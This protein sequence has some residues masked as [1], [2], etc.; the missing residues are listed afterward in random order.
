ML[1]RVHIKGFKSISDA[2]ISLGRVNVFI[3][4]NGAGKSNLLEAI[5]MLSSSFEGGIDYERLARRG[6]RLSSPEIFRSSLKNKERLKTFS[7]EAEMGEMVYSSQVTSVSKF[8]YHSESLVSKDGAKLAGR[9]NVGARIDGVP[10]KGKLDPT[11]SIIAPYRAFG[12]DA[13]ARGVLEDIEKYGIFSL[14]T[15]ILR[16]VAEDKSQKSPLGLYGGR[17]AEA[18]NEVARDQGNREHL[19]R[20]FALMDWFRSIG[21]TTEVDKTLISDK[22]T[23]GR[24]VLT[25]RDKFMKGS[26]DHLYGYDVSEGALYVLFVL[27]LLT[28]KDAPN[29]FALD[30][31]DTALNPGLVR[32]FMSHIIELVCASEKKQI[33]ITTHNPTTLDAI[34]IFNP[35]HRLF[36]VQRMEDGQTEF[37]RIEP[38]DGMTKDGWQNQYFG[39]KMSEIWLSGAMG[40]LPTGF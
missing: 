1:N 31:V 40:G 19:Q 36:V 37:R 35:E 30:N 11:K 8:N 4:T 24:T 34:D 38:P 6:A 3:G 26:F 25:Y 23:L 2:N 16:G 9:S 28:H 22:V 7:I 33:F 18:F 32:Q 20:F 17:L 12:E 29:I 10:L 5:A 15:P 13:S 14:S 27:V 21:V 39:L